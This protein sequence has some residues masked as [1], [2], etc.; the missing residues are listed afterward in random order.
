MSIPIEP[1]DSSK[2]SNEKSGGI[3][4]YKPDFKVIFI[5]NLLSL[6]KIHLLL[7]Q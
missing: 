4:T 3:K 5:V 7:V 1:G 6:I 2:G